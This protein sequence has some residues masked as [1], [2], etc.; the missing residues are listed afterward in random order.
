MP[1]NEV[2]F[3]SVQSIGVDSIRADNA[4]A[5]CVGDCSFDSIMS[6]VSSSD[7]GSQSELTLS[8]GTSVSLLGE[9]DLGQ[10]LLSSVMSVK[11]DGLSRAETLQKK[12]DGLKA[13]EADTP[14]DAASIIERQKE[15]SIKLMD[16]QDQRT[17][18]HLLMSFQTN[19]LK[20][21][22]EGIQ[23]LVKG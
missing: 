21:S 19:S 23:Q 6:S 17:N 2:A 11:S 20:K 18:D 12:V 16:L 14:N 7:V 9:N 10:K 13:P 3:S 5:H 1:V 4:S 15:F 8:D 22:G